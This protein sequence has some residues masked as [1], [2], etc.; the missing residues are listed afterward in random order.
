MA[1]DK[2]QT[3]ENQVQQSERKYDTVS[4]PSDPPSDQPPSFTSETGQSVDPGTAQQSQ[5]QENDSGGSSSS[6]QEEK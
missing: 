3:K 6:S 4:N 5:G 2:K 1:E